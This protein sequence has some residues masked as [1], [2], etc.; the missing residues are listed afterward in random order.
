MYKN[1]FFLN[2]L[3]LE[4]AQQLKNFRIIEAYSQEKDKLVL[5][6]Q[7][8]ELQKH[9]EISVNSSSPYFLVKEKMNRAKRNT[10]AFFSDVLPA[11]IG[12][13]LIAENDRIIKIAGNNFALYFFIRG[14]DSNIFVENSAG[15]IF[16]F[17]DCE[18]DLQKLI[19]DDLSKAKYINTFYKP[20]LNGF[21]AGHFEQY[22][23]ENYRSISKDIIREAKFRVPDEAE[24]S[25]RKEIETVLD[26][27][28]L[29]SAAFFFQ[30]GYKR[31]ACSR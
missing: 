11:V 14:G 2:R 15:V 26:E 17:K 3:V 16:T 8:G 13:V 9:I 5:N 1:Y 6:L 19:A 23:K 28:Q 27:I 10:V 29:N 12:D 30:R 4:L 7:K 25:L 24:D 20:E 22:I 31:N 21:S 18:A